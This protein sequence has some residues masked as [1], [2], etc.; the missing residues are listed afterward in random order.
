[1]RIGFDASSI[2]GER[3]GVGWHTYYLLRALVNLK[4][5]L[6]LIA[7]VPPGF[8]EDGAVPGW[9]HASGLRWVEAGKMMMPWRGRLDRLDLFHGANS[10]MRTVG[11]AGGL[12]AVYG[13]RVD[14]APPYSTEPLAQ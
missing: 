9:E 6:E 4:E 13:P 8:L 12:C 14:P 3:G 5:D 7:Y 2:V 1:M 10:K 11:R